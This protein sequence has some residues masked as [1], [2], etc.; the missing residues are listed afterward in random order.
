M[1]TPNEKDT[2]AVAGGAIGASSPEEQRSSIVI[3]LGMN[4]P[5]LANRVGK[6][7]ENQLE[8]LTDPRRGP[9]YQFDSA[10][11]Y[12]ANG[13]LSIL[14]RL[15]NLVFAKN[16]NESNNGVFRLD[17]E[18]NHMFSNA[19]NTTLGSTNID[20]LDGY[21]IHPLGTTYPSTN[22]SPKKTWIKQLFP[23]FGIKNI[24]KITILELV[25]GLLFETIDALKNSPANVVDSDEE[26]IDLGT[27][28]ID[29]EDQFL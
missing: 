12:Y 2:W 3:P 21:I 14:A 13:S 1:T 28:I 6:A 8:A 22:F 9:K 17:Q 4:L 15:G 7:A 25:Q 5:Q 18:N 23:A 27:Q 26:F 29:N 19:E 10:V 16:I 20:T 11:N 24:V